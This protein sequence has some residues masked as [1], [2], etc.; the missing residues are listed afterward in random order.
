MER[1]PGPA[2]GVAMHVGGHCLVPGRRCAD[3]LSWVTSRSPRGHAGCE[4]C[5]GRD[6]PCVHAIRCAEPGLDGVA[7]GGVVERI[8]PVARG[9]SGAVAGKPG[10]CPTV[11]AGMPSTLGG[12]ARHESYNSGEGEDPPARDAG[13]VYESLGSVAVYEEYATDDTGSGKSGVMSAGSLL[14]ASFGLMY[15]CATGTYHGTAPGPCTPAAGR[16]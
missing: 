2:R 12:K 7:V 8:W 16:G 1:W 5:S 4:R 9:G 14:S 15:G 11:L 10:R 3:G 6:E 13:V